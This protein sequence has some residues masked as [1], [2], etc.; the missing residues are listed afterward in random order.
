MVNHHNSTALKSTINIKIAKV[1]FPVMLPLLFALFAFYP[2]KTFEVSTTAG[3]N[4]NTITLIF[5]GDIM[6]HMPQV[7]AAWNDSLG[8]YDYNSCFAPVKDL[9]ASADIT[10][11]NFETTLDG[12]PYSGYPA[13]SS[14]DAIVNALLTSG[15]DYVG[16]ANNHCCD[17]GYSGITRTI[18]VLDSLHLG[19]T[20]T[21]ASENEYNRVNPLIIK[22]NGFRIA[23]LN[24][25]YGTNG[26]PVP[27]NTIVNLLDENTILHDVKAAKDSLVDEIIAFVHW[28]NEYERK[29][30]LEQKRWRDYFNSLGVRI[31]IGSHPHVL[32]PMDWEQADTVHAERLTV[33]SL[34]NFVSNQRKQYT[35]GGAVVQITL[36]KKGNQTAI[37][38]VNYTLTWVHTPFVEGK[39]Q[40]RIMQV[41][42]FETDSSAFNQ[43]DF[44]LM[45][46]FIFDSRQLLKTN[47]NILEK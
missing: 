4:E 33:W 47:I 28:G 15:I 3:E 18:Q 23:L 25:T 44:S 42:Q 10:I 19:H 20:G 17:R 41:K 34:G 16:T 27:K 24:Y 35:D 39:K 45:Q 21:F 43:Q 5:A 29:P 9:L 31:V 32:Q 11:A 22:K 7:E 8:I 12:K 46:T 1:A 38:D 14:P 6:Q 30:N 37:K 36:G 13:F 26:L 40:Y 2:A